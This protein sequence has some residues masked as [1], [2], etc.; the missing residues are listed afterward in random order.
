VPASY[1]KIHGAWASVSVAA[2]VGSEM[3][4]HITGW[5][6]RRHI[7]VQSTWNRR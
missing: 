6:A 4:V 1:S 2:C 7:C 3:S 5:P